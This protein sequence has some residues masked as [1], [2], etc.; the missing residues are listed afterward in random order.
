MWCKLTRILD[1]YRWL[2]FL[3]ILLSLFLWLCCGHADSGTTGR[4]TSVN[5]LCVWVSHVIVHTRIVF[6]CHM[7]AM[8]VP[9][10]LTWCGGGSGSV[11]RSR[12]NSWQALQQFVQD[13]DREWQ[14]KHCYPLSPIQRSDLE[15]TL[16][17]K[18]EEKPRTYQHFELGSI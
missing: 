17:G 15:D 4:M 10:R 5:G 8:C 6:D 2:C 14:L 12:H 9:P 16:M 3:R 11:T 7:S 18:G 13:N 1:Y